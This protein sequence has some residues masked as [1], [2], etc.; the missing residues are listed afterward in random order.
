[1]LLSHTYRFIYTKTLKTAGTSVEIYFEDACI[2]PGSA[3]VR[4]HRIEQ[5]VTPA[6]VIGYRGPDPSGRTWYNHMSAG[7]IRKLAGY[8]TWNDYRKFCVVRNPF[9]KMVSLWWFNIAKQGLRYEGYPFSAIKS[10]FSRWCVGHAP[11][12]IDR[13][14]YM[15]DGAVAMDYFIQYE[16][17][18]QGL[19]NVCRQVGYPF[20]PETL[21]QY[22]SAARMTRQPFA[23]Y[24][25]EFA[26]AAVEANFSW[27]LDYFGYRR[28][29]QTTADA[30]RLR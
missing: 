5:T 15:I 4:G 27:E 20:R 12:A 26:I 17:L 24:Y 29:S 3:I 25:D 30:E 7:E 6:G 13:D 21:G 18:L 1:M 8:E 28:L 22:K 16:F 14:K 2:P 11:D 9:D 10:D 19:E 23:D